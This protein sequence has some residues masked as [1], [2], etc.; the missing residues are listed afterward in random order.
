MDALPSAF[1]IP[2]SI[3][4]LLLNR[5]DIPNSPANI[6]NPLALPYS[7]VHKF[8]TKETEKAHEL[9][10]FTR[11]KKSGLLG[12]I[13]IKSNW[14]NDNQVMKDGSSIPRRSTL[15]KSLPLLLRMPYIKNYSEWPEIYKE[16]IFQ[17]K[18]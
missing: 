3:I 14:I 11:Y 6:L 15:F 4:D 1:Y 10:L 7:Q 5:N 12:I 8:P 16:K 13:R 2:K 17:Q 18:I 9:Q